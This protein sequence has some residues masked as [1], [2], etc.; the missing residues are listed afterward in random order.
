MFNSNDKKSTVGKVKTNASGTNNLPSVNMIS[1]GT[2]VK[3]TLR[4]KNDIR[5]AGDLDG[6]AIA[7]GKVIVSSTGKVDGNIQAVDA[8]VAGH[9]DGEIKVKNKLI[10]RQAA[11]VEGDIFTKSLLV[12]EGAQINGACHMNESGGTDFLKKSDKSK[13]ES[14]KEKVSEPQ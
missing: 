5:I 12:E 11:T 14:T 10:L 8:D 2:S 9:V 3:G 13:S 4:T 1:E 7:D 6:E